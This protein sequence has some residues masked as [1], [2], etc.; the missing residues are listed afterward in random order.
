M[1][2]DSCWL[3]VEVLWTCWTLQNHDRRLREL[4]LLPRRIK[5]YEIWSSS[6]QVKTRQ[7]DTQHSKLPSQHAIGATKAIATTK[8][9]KMNFLCLKVFTRALIDTVSMWTS[10][11]L[12][13]YLL[14]GNS[15]DETIPCGESLVPWYRNHCSKQSEGL[16]KTSDY[17]PNSHTTR[18]FANDR[19]PTC[20]VGISIDGF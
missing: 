5:S 3:S 1:Q 13:T 16:F 11:R 7:R 17:N 2:R 12:N 8:T 14:P 19:T 15:E 6:K 18:A 10:S 20:P 9:L 4:C